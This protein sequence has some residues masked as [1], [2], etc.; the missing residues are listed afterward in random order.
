MVATSFVTA[1]RERRAPAFS[2]HVV[3]HAV[4]VALGPL[5][6]GAAG[7]PRFLLVVLLLLV[8]VVVRGPGVLE[9]LVVAGALRSRVGPRALTCRASF[10]WTW[11]RD[12]PSTT[13]RRSRGVSVDPP[14][15]YPCGTPRRGRDPPS[16]TARLR[17]FAARGAG[18]ARRPAAAAAAGDAGDAPPVRVRRFRQFADLLGLTPR[19]AP[20]YA[21]RVAAAYCCV[22]RETLGARRVAA[23]LAP[24]SR[25]GR[26]RRDGH[27]VPLEDV[28]AAAG[29]PLAELAAPWAGAAF[30]AELQDATTRVC[31]AP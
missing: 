26:P 31:C 25:D 16:T 19:A 3:G 28:L 1:L 17:Y 6:G 29:A 22:L 20:L 10:S 14:S 12:P 9:G 23:A 4:V 5:L 15:E 11:H 27:R 7:E 21:P 13:A 24:E 2:L 18:G 8:V 30:C